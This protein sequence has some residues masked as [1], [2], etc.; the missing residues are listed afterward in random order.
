MMK[1][2]GVHGN[3]FAIDDGVGTLAL[4]DQTQRGCA[5]TVGPVRPHREESSESRRRATS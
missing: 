1:S 5:M 4:H 3:L 2:P